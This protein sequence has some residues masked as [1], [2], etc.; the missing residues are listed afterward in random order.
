MNPSLHHPNTATA[1]LIDLVQRA[2][3][4]NPPAPDAMV[5]VEVVIP[6]H[7]EERILATSIYRLHSFLRAEGPMS[8]RIV[9]ADNA[10]TDCTLEI[11]HA[12]VVAYM[13]V[14]LSTDLK[15]LAPL[16]APLLSGH[17]EVAIG[18]RLSRPE[19]RCGSCPNSQPAGSVAW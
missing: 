1:E 8:W 2:H 11:A 3:G 9:I 19:R 14:D 18:T 5:D 15:A 12:L 13:D 7:N 6:T 4:R 10:S 16:V 17:S